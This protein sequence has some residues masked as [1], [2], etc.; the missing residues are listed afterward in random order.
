MVIPARFDEV[1]AVAHEIEQF[2]QKA[3]FCDQAVFDIQLAIEEIVINIIRHGF[4]GNPGLIS[5]HS[6]VDSDLLTVEII[7]EAPPFN[8]LSVPDP[9][10]TSSLAERKTGGLGIYLVR[11]VTDTV[12]YRYENKKNIL[13][14][15]KKKQ[16]DAVS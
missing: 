13:I 6:I 2:M 7:D 14:F 10:I 16:K 15:T 12:T 3:G 5:I 4:C 8:P 11:Q 1:P 9:D